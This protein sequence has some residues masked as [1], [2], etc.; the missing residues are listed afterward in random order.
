MSINPERAV[1]A[2]NAVPKMAVIWH[3]GPG[4]AH[5]L[6]G[7]EIKFLCPVC[8]H[9][10]MASLPVPTYDREELKVSEASIYCSNDGCMQEY[11]FTAV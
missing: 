6:A 4:P 5:L 2:G 9:W 3:G 8:G 10:T 7:I 1:G 11:K